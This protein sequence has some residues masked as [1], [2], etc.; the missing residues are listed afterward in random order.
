M[1]RYIDVDELISLLQDDIEVCD[2]ESDMERGCIIGL[3]M[4]IC[5]AQALISNEGAECLVCHGTG[6]IGTTNWLMEGMTKEE[7]ARKKADAVVEAEREIEEAD[8]TMRAEVAREI[9]AELT[10]SYPDE[11]FTGGI[12]ITREELYELKQKYGIE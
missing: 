1:T 10:V 7:F 12:C 9:F 4:A 11:Y 6:R 2:V 5:Y 3:K 8:R